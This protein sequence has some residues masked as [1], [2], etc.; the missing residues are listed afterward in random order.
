MI[1]SALNQYIVVKHS[2]T[3]NMIYKT[4]IEYI[5]T[6]SKKIKR[7]YKAENP[8]TLGSHILIIAKDFLN[9]LIY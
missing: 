2:Y 9:P 1:N 6:I 8:Y 4:I 5:N 7:L 3:L